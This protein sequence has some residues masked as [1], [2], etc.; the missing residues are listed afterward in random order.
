MNGSTE[1]LSPA[2]RSTNVPDARPSVAIVSNSQTPYRLH[3]HLRVAREIPEVRLWSLYTHEVSNAPWAFHVPEEIGSVLFGKGESCDA[4][5]DPR[6]S[7]REWR[8]GGIII[9]WFKEHDVRFVVMMGYND[10]G[11][12]RMIRWC[13]GAGIPCFLFGDSN[14]L[15]DLASGLKAKVKRAVVS[16]A[17]GWCAGTLSCG[18]LGRDYFVKYGGKPERNFFFPYEPD[19]DLIQNLSEETIRKARE[20]FSLDP[21][22]RRVVFSGRQ[23]PLKRPDLLV[24]AFVA[25]AAARPE[26]TCW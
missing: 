7:L 20:R 4:Q 5:A 11:R 14:I 8:R 25:I 21:A 3:L 2:V 13:R 18:T 16:R 12:M 26:W 15:G 10:A 6:H 17:V 19:Y 9:R 22:R 24:D 1:A 23:V